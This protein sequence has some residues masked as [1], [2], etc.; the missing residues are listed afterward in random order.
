[1]RLHIISD[2]FER[3]QRTLR[4]IDHGLVLQDA[5][6]VRNVNGRGLR[7]E[8]RVDAL[9]LGVPLAEGLERGDGL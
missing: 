4:L 7:R 6:V 9:S 1:M 5:A 2:G 8:R 3:L